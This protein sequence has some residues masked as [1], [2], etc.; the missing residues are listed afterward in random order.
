MDVDDRLQALA[1]RL[2]QLEAE[3]ARLRAA[4]TTERAEAV[5]VP[6]TLRVPVS[7]RTWLA[8]SAAVVAGAV[9]GGA[10]M[11][12]P[13]AAAG[14]VFLDIDNAGSAPTTITAALGTD[15]FT[16][17]FGST[18]SDPDQGTG[19]FGYGPSF[20]TLGFSAL[21]TGL[22]GKASGDDF[23]SA[24]GTGG[25]IDNPA[26]PGSIGVQGEASGDGQIGV[27]GISDVGWGAWFESNFADI[28]IGKSN[29][30]APL[31]DTG[32]IHYFGD[33]VAENNGTNSVLWYCVQT[34]IPGTWRRLAGPN[35]AGAT[36]LLASPIRVYDSRPLSQPLAI[37]PKTP[38]AMDAERVI[39]CTGNASGVPV[40][41]VAVLI[42]LTAVG[43]SG[44]GWLSVRAN[45]SVYAN[46]SNLNWSAANQTL[47]NSAT[48]KCGANATIL[49]RLGGAA[50]TNFIVDVIGYMR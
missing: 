15:L 27:K 43:Q 5:D 9:A 1:A 12:S 13:A 34:G 11:A 23:T 31:G 8:R 40:D 16:T 24:V 48:V 45:G 21:G 49:V 42:N 29:R 14:E 2:D 28:T 46:T 30:T 25:Y 10:A 32:V 47:A 17:V 39:D 38:L 19:L 7:R 20:G 41:A 35:T 6:G 18:N 4:L 22:W 44:G 36:T 50:S 26:S 3:N 37:G 33:V